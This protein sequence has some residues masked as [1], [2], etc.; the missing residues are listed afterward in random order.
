MQA[1]GLYYAP[2]NLDIIIS[3]T[4]K[5]NFVIENIKKVGCPFT[6]YEPSST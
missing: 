2:I 1:K 4:R 6:A 5:V 3:L